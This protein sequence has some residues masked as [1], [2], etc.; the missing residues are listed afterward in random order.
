MSLYSIQIKKS[1]L[2]SEDLAD[3]SN[4]LD[5]ISRDISNVS[6][7]MSYVDGSVLHKMTTIE[8]KLSDINLNVKVLRKA[9][10]SSTDRY[11]SCEETVLNKNADTRGVCRSRSGDSETGSNDLYG[12]LKNN[13]VRKL[14][15][16]Y[17]HAVR[18]IMNLHWTQELSYLFSNIRRIVNSLFSGAASNQQ[19]ADAVAEAFLNDPL[20]CRSVI[21]D[22]IKKWTYDKDAYVIDPKLL[23]MAKKTA[24]Y[25]I[26]GFDKNTKSFI[27]DVVNIFGVTANANAIIAEYRCNVEILRSIRRGLEDN[28][29]LAQTVDQLIKEYNSYSH[30]WIDSAASKA[31]NAGVSVLEVVTNMPF[32][33]VTK[34]IE[35]GAGSIPSSIGIEK[36]VSTTELLNS[37][38]NAL[39]KAS[40]VIKSGN[41]TAEDIET[42]SNTFYLVKSLK[43][44]QYEGMRNC[45]SSSS[46]EYEFLSNEIAKLELM[47]PDGHWM[48]AGDIATWDGRTIMSRMGGGNGAIGGGSIGGGRKEN[49]STGGGVVGSR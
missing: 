17:N 33:S 27:K 1:R 40:D 47:E 11:Y 34:V 9:L 39:E 48:D 49:G 7:N 31:E 3:I 6:A 37:S 13:D 26:L 8:S 2:S 12:Y 38:M 4:K 35:K 21:S 28:T 5:G 29:V 44:T 36:V 43:I 19:Y 14:F 46:A 25:S 18:F 20:M 45:V 32:V 24:D 30:K 10:Q 42:Y 22:I 15:G 41:Y 16:S 23:E